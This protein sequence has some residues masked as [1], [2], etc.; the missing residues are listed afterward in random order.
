MTSGSPTVER[1]AESSGW[2]GGAAFFCIMALAGFLLVR[3]IKNRGNG[4]PFG[5][6]KMSEEDIAALAAQASVILKCSWEEEDLTI[7]DKGGALGTGF[8]IQA[9]DGEATILSNLHVLDLQRIAESDVLCTDRPELKSYFLTATF[10]DGAVVKVES[11]KCNPKLKD[12]VALTTALPDSTLTPLTLSQVKP[13]QGGKVYAMGN[14]M[15]LEFA[16]SSGSVSRYDVFP[17]K[18]GAPVQIIQTTTPISPGNSGGP[19]LDEYGLV[20]GINTSS[21]ADK[22]AQSLNFAISSIEVL[23]SAKEEGWVSLPLNPA[24]LGEAAFALLCK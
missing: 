20:V 12:F 22:E 18:A 15:G 17:S 21:L 6:S 16:F 10:R 11:V 23:R 3:L 24:S 4:F 2:I 14:P 5:K 8:V 9:K 1:P 13:K 19:L 7:N